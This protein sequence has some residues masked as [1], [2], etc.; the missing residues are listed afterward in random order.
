MDIDIG[1]WDVLPGYLILSPVF[2][3]F[4]FYCVRDVWDMKIGQVRHFYIFTSRFVTFGWSKA[5]DLM[6]NFLSQRTTDHRT[7]I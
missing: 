3:Y 6:R 4:K 5:S 7:T 1:I 2:N